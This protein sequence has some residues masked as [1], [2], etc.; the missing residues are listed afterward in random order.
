MQLHFTQYLTF[1]LQDFLKPSFKQSKSPLH[2]HLTDSHHFFLW[3]K[4]HKCAKK[5]NNYKAACAAWLLQRAGMTTVA[6]LLLQPACRGHQCVTR[7]DG[8]LQV[9]EG[10][11]SHQSWGHSSV[12]VATH[13]AIPERCVLLLKMCVNGRIMFCSGVTCNNRCL[14]F[15]DDKLIKEEESE[16]RI[17][18]NN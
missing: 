9:T 16:S 6:V 8:T 2:P 1:I 10:P 17:I 4:R 5:Y 7:H 18:K 3:Q 11:S 14:F 15:H 13:T 12:V